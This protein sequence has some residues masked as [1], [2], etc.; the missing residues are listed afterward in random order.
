MSKAT[1]VR[2]RCRPRRKVNAEDQTAYRL[3]IMR[4]P[5]LYQVQIDIVLY[6]IYYQSYH[7]FQYKYLTYIFY[8][9]L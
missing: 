3:E 7:K 4:H 8:N 2:C 1:P 5:S 6:E 9:M